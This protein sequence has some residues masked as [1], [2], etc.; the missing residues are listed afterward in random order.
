LTGTLAAF[1]LA[2][3][4]TVTVS[5]TLSTVTGDTF[6][7]GSWFRDASGAEEDLIEQSCLQHDSWESRKRT[8]GLRDIS[9]MAC[10]LQATVLLWFIEPPMVALLAMVL[11]F[12]SVELLA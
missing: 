4:V 8:E 5:S 1:T 10:F 3:L 6:L 7:G 12:D 11:C 2:V 9:A